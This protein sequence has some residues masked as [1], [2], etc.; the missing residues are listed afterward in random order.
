MSVL[1]ECISVIVRRSVIERR[2]P[3]G[4]AGYKAACPNRTFCADEHLVRIGFLAERDPGMFL[5]SCLGHVGLVSSPTGRLEDLEVQSAFVAVVEQRLGP[6]HPEHSSWL[7]YAE[8]PDG[9]SICWL[10]GEP[11]G[12]LVA[13]PGWKP[14]DSRSKIKLEGVHGVKTATSLGE[15]PPVPE[16][17]VRLFTTQVYGTKDY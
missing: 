2:Y 9:V 14:E 16:G 11:Q 5:L 4:L 12:E 3:G 17:H 1:V 7:E 6:W 15:L 8:R 13:P 10:A